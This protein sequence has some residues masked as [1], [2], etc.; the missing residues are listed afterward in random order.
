MNTPTMNT[1]STLTAL[2]AFSD[3]YIWL[4]A[5]PTGGAV[6]VDP[7]QSGPVLAALERGLTIDAILLTHHHHDH[8]GGAADLIDR[9]GAPC[10]APVDPR[11]DLPCTRV[12]AGD[13]VQAGG[14]RFEVLEL[15]GH[16]LTHVAF[17]GD[18]LLFCGDTLFSL[19]CG[20]LFEGSPAQMLASL[21]RLAALPA[22]TRV[23]CGHEYTLDNASFARAVDPDNVA[24]IRYIEQVRR[25]RDEGRP[26]LP[27]TIEIEL[28]CNPFL[29]IDRPALVAAAAARLGRQPRDRIECFAEL[30]RFKDG[31]RAA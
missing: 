31:F 16:T 4:L 21:D 26:S 25:I 29:G 2:P 5:A 15:P 12:G 10:Y 9:T 17:V 27:S 22:A 1:N 7:G 30:R 19:G 24:L 11:I 3:N 23:C 8:I 18:G 14:H 28:R 20:R 6:V 13:V